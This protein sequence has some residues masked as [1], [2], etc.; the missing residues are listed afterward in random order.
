MGKEQLMPFFFF[1]VF[2]LIS[3]TITASSSSFSSPSTYCQKHPDCKCSA[4]FKQVKCTF[5]SSSST[6]TSTLDFIDTRVLK[7][8]VSHSN[9]TNLVFGDVSLNIDTL[10]LT[11][12]RLAIIHEKM[13]A[14][15]PHLKYLDLSMNEI[16]AINDESV[17]DSQNV[18]EHLNLSQA[19]TNEHKMWRDLCGLINLRVLDVSYADLSEFTLECWKKTDGKL[20]SFY[21]RHARN[22]EATI[23]KWLPYLGECFFL[24]RFKNLGVGALKLVENYG[25]FG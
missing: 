14:R 2:L 9:L 19:F 8:D 24:L 10:I 16:K 11:D 25:C 15:L 3:S 12:N 22:V 18:L 23:L 4:D 20:V 1:L 7:L 13:F 21:A 5:N 17:F 6:Y